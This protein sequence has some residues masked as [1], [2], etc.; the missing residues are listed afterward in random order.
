MEFE[1]IGVIKMGRLKWLNSVEE[2]NKYG[3]VLLE[4]ENKIKKII[5]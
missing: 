3:Y 4:L 1:V 2:L 5:K